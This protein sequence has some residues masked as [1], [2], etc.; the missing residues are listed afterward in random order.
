VRGS[1]IEPDGFTG[2]T[3]V[4]LLCRNSQAGLLFHRGREGIG[5]GFKKV[6]KFCIIDIWALLD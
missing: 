3:P 6:G 1:W 5:A 2:G 4:P